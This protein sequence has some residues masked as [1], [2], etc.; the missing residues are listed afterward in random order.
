VI[1]AANVP[2]ATRGKNGRTLSSYRLCRSSRSAKTR[3]PV[4]RGASRPH[5]QNHQPATPNPGCLAWIFK[6]NIRLSFASRSQAAQLFQPSRL[7]GP[8]FWNLSLGPVLALRTLVSTRIHPR[9]Q[10]P[11]TDVVAGT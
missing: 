8:A 7:I 11:W 9:G 6:R 5:G 1:A 4:A 3:S 2:P 10:E